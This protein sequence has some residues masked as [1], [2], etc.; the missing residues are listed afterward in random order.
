MLDGKT[1]LL[2]VTGG[3]AAY[4]A[5]VL[6]SKLVQKGA[7][8]HVIMTES[9]ARFITPLTLQTLSR[10]PVHT[11]TFNEEDPAVVAH[12]NLADR[13]DLVL[14]APATANSLA[15]LAAGLADDMLSTTLLATTAPIIAAPAMNVHMYEHPAT[16]ANMETLGRRGVRFI[17]PGTGQLACGYV[18]KGR[19]AEPEEIVQAVELYLASRSMLLGKEVVVTAGGTVE[20]FDPVRYLTNDSSGKMGFAIAEAARDLGAQVTLIAARTTAPTPGGVELVQVESAQQMLDAVL[21]R[22]D[23]A[24]V[25]VKAAAVADYR[26]IIRHETKLKKTGD[27]LIIEM[28]KT[29][30]ILA[31]LGRRKNG[32]F[33]VGFAAETDR[34]EEHAMDKLQRKNCDLIVANDVTMEG[35]GFNVDTNAVSIFDRDGLVEALPV[36]GKRETADRLM[37]LVA[38]R[39]AGSAKA[40]VKL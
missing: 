19:L 16:V 23:S 12:I 9:A 36:L 3:I 2:G 27:T 21:S 7:Q 6:C 28:E 14:I 38:D 20:R 32:Q 40:G 15:K 37:R 5:A 4:K 26:P 33:L 17:D 11:D 10:N 13:A 34:L 30:D 22:A 31:E 29:T 1:I 25:V 35:A 24:D 8:V 39:L 18:A